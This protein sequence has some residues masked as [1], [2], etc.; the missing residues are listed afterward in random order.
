MKKTVTITAA[1]IVLIVL[2]ATAALFTLGA[3]AGSHQTC[4]RV[5]PAEVRS[6]GDPHF[7]NKLQKLA[8]CEH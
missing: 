1:A 5:K 6:A 7:P 2:A 8:R 3:V 4:G